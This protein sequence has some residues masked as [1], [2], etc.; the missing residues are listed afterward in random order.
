[1][2]RPAYIKQPGPIAAERIIAVATRGRSV[3][4]GLEP[5]K[6][7]VEAVAAKFA[8]HGIASG[9]VDVSGLAVGPFAYVMPALSKTG[10]NAAFYSDVFRPKG[11]TRIKHGAMTFGRRDGAPYFHTHAL[12]TEAD[13]TFTG[14]HI[15]P[16]ETVVAEGIDV[17][18]FGMADAVFEGNHDPETNFKLFG[19]MDVQS[20]AVGPVGLRAYAAR[21]RPNQDF[22][23]ALEAFCA[24]NKITHARIH[25]GV[26]STI[27]AAFDD[28]RI[29]E[30]FAT[31]VYIKTGVIEPGADGQPVAQIDVGL[32]DYTGATAE[33]RLARGQNP[34]LMTFELVIE[35][36]S[37]VG[38]NRKARRT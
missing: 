17:A 35:V 9:S 5:G 15:L 25:G 13:G 36:I 10:E 27:G 34:V 22:T 4:L 21:L 12:W 11:I 20:T 18:T 16:D 28:G 1:M 33:G 23:G 14:G 7:L 31:E 8:A 38:E 2:S 19:P 3:A 37:S 29:V 26:G 30:N 6:R 24:G 32:I